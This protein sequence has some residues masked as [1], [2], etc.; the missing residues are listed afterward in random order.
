MRTELKKRVASAEEIRASKVRKELDAQM[1]ASM[2]RLRFALYAAL[3]EEG[4]QSGCHLT[5]RADEI[6]TESRSFPDLVVGLHLRISSGS[7]TDD[8][9]RSLNSLPAKDLKNFEMTAKDI[10]AMYWRLFTDY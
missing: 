3:I 8:D 7:I 1:Y 9:I 4:G 6:D 5:N 2:N 10:V